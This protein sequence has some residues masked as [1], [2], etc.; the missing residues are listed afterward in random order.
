MAQTHASLHFVGSYP[1]YVAI[2]KQAKR[3]N[4]AIALTSK[5]GASSLYVFML[6]RWRRFF[7][8]NLQDTEIAA[9]VPLS[10]YQNI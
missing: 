4:G 9:S 10:D 8:G 1:S 6:K 7:S 2:L 5:E 3:T